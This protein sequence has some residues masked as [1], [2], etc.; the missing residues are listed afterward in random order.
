MRRRMWDGSV[1]GVGR[2]VDGRICGA[3]G[4]GYNGPVEAYGGGGGGEDFMS[5]T[6]MAEKSCC[7]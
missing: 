1:G 2:V 6:T 4:G 5:R 3:N 7:L